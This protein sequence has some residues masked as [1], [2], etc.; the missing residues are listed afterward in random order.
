MRMSTYVRTYLP[1][2]GRISVCQAV[3]IYCD[4]EGQATP[5]KGHHLGDRGSER[6]SGEE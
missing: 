5:G 6:G 4:I 2:F 3:R 1:L